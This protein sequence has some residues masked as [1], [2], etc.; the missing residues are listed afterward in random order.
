MGYTL[1]TPDWRFTEWYNWDRAACVAQWAAPP[2]G[3][4]LYNHTGQ[5]L[6]DMDSFENENVAADPANAPLVAALRGKLWARFK[7]AGTG[8][9]PD[10]PGSMERF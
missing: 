8:C 7:S 4:E 10:Q 3:T 9:P 6:G 5:T 2:H 1:R